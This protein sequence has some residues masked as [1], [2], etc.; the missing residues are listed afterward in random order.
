MSFLF[1]R[2]ACCMAPGLS[3]ETR[4]SSVYHRLINM[5]CSYESYLFPLIYSAQMLALQQWHNSCS[6]EENRWGSM[7]SKK[8]K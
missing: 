7:G 5:D 2:Y 6:Q 1:T 8:K 4:S 3:L